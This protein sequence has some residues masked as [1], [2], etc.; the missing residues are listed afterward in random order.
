MSGVRVRG[1]W[2]GW[3]GSSAGIGHKDSVS[4]LY[5]GNELFLAAEALEPSCVLQRQLW[6]RLPREVEHPGEVTS[7]GELCV[8]MSSVSWVSCLFLP[9][10][11]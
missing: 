5:R 2:R 6:L 4:F 7:W 3:E 1:G 11:L 10:A 9:S 8:S